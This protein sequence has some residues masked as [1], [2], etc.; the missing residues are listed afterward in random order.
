M[1]VLPGVWRPGRLN[2]SVV[3]LCCAV[4]LLTACAEEAPVPRN[5]FFADSLGIDPQR[6]VQ[7]V[8]IGGARNE[9]HVVPGELTV[10]PDGVV[11]LRTVDHRVHTLTF[12]RDSLSDEGRAFIAA[13][14]GFVIGPL[15]ERGSAVAID[16]A[17]APPGRYAFVSEGSGGVASGSIVV[18][19]GRDGG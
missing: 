16:F 19:S 6:S 14:V 17:D 4:V 8:L 5:P 1:G 12:L 3:G 7:S 18:P 2:Y 15:V 13:S 10:S 11:V 9:E